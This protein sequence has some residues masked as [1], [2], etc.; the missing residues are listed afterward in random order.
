MSAPVDFGAIRSEFGLASAYPAEAT[1][2]ARDAIDAFAGARADRTDIPFVTI[3]PPGAMDLDQAVHIEH[4]SSGFTV[5][6]AIADVGAVIDPAGPLAREAGVRGQTFYLPDGTVPLHPPILS[7]NSA[8]LL[9]DQDRPAALWTIECDENAEPQ[10]FSV[11][12]ATVRSRARLDYASVQADADANRLHPSIAALPEFGT[13]RIEAGLARGAIGLRLPA[14]SVIRDDKAVGH[15]RLVVEPRTAADDW[16]EQISLLTGIC[17]AQIMLHGGGSDGVPSVGERIAL[18]RTMPPPTESAIDS[19][20]RT[21][22]ALG[23]DW[24]ADQSVGRLL[25]GLDPN[26]PATLVLMSEAT[27][28]LRGAGYTVLDGA[29]AGGNGA[30]AVARSAGGAPPVS[31]VR[32]TG[33][34]WSAS[35]V[36]LAADSRSAGD[37]E[38]RGVVGA[39]GRAGSVGGGGTSGG[40]GSAGIRGAV[41]SAGSVGGGRTS[42]RPASNPQTG[43]NLQH[44]AIGAPYAHVTAPLRRLADRFAIEICLARCAG[45]E[46]PQ[47]VRDGLVPTA[48]SM[49]RSDSLAGKVERAC[50]DLTESTLLAERSGAI[51]EAVVVREANGTRPAEVFIADPPVVGPCIGAP[52]EGAQVQ[53]RL[54]AADP[55]TRKISF[56]YPV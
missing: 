3:D 48:E 46:V 21:A 31:G 26:A 30:G 6:Y 2:A 34:G 37:S 22:A 32:S 23:V 45:T 54:V 25:A 11:V 27:G 56:G 9:P 12:R 55:T 44:S 4:A 10:R 7:E 20:R 17:A 13:R 43:N 18:L 51:F 5:H 14:Q 24:P 28:L 41:G 16:N 52:P 47:W 39:P 49:K 29:V 35:G 38:S 15:W 53:V 50:I 8:S 19:M 33:G 40:K 1:A 42:A 36:E